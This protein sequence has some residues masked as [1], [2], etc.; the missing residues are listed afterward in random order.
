MNHNQQRPPWMDIVL[1]V[2]QASSVQHWQQVQSL[3]SGGQV[4]RCSLAGASFKTVIVK[5]CNFQRTRIIPAVGQPT[6][7]MNARHTRI[8]SNRIGAKITSLCTESSGSHVGHNIQR[9]GVHGLEDLD[10]VGFPH[11]T[12]VTDVTNASGGRPFPC[13]VSALNQRDYGTSE[14]TGASN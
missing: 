1:D 2:T 5:H 14:R 10:A 6:V 8:G 4:V 13:H 11:R 3:W 9:P 12:T 7:P